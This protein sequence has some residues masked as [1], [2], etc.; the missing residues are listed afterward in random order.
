MNGSR[1]QQ[2]RLAPVGKLGNVRGELGRVAHLCSCLPR[3]NHKSGC[4]ILAAAVA[5]RVGTTNAKP[6]APAQTA[7]RFRQV[8]F[9][10]TC[11]QL[12]LVGA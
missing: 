3:P 12:T 5:A 7:I 9:P 10:P 1:A 11:R 8:V 2:Q 6:F 4:P